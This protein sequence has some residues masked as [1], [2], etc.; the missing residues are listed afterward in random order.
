MG[1]VEIR[2]RDRGSMRKAM[3]NAQG[4]RTPVDFAMLFLNKNDPATYA[5]FKGL[6]DRVFGFNSI[7]ATRRCIADKQGEKFSN[8]MLKMNLK[9]SGTNH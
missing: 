4:Q 2:L 6:A 8:I 3:T 9:A 1:T 5:Y 7:C